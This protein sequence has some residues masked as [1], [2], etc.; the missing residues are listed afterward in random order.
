MFSIPLLAPSI[1]YGCES[2]AKKKT[3]SIVKCNFFSVQVNRTKFPL[4]KKARNTVSPSFRLGHVLTMV[5]RTSLDSIV[6]NY[7]GFFTLRR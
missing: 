3:F 2:Y 5:W 7:R 6:S 1:L 4:D